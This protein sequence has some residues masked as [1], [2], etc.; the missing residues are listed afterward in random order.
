VG[1]RLGCEEADMSGERDTTRIESDTMG[2]MEIP[3]WA[4]WGAQTQRAVENFAV[5]D[6]RI[7]VSMIKALGLIKRYAA[8]ANRELALLDKKLA[9]AVC[10][11]A[12]EVIEGRW[13][14]HF[15]IDVFQTG[16]GTSWNM[17]ANEVISNRANEILGAPLGAK[18][19][20]HPN[21]H[22]NKGQSSNDVIPTAIHIADRLEIDSLIEA[23]LDLQKALETKAEDFKEV[24]KIGRT[25]LQDAVPM[26]LGQEF[27]GYAS[28][29]RKSVTR[30]KGCLPH[31]EEL[32]LG[33]TAIGT[34][35]NA[36][37]EMA[38]RAIGLIAAKTG[39]PFRTADSL[40]EAI[41]SRDAQ[42]ELMGALNT[43]A[44]AL[45]KIANDLRLLASGPRA[46]F[47]EIVLPSLQPGSSIMPGKVN[48]VIPEMVIQAA[49]HVMGKHYTVSIGAQNAPLELNMMNPLIGYETIASITLLANTCNALAERCI[50]GLEAD[51]ERCAYWVEWS[52]ALVTPLATKI[53]YDKAAAL[54]YKAYKSKRTIRE[55]V[56]EEKIFSDQE[57]DELLDPKRMI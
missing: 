33:G 35:L 14:Q 50:R 13:N 24:I 3:G 21:D 11:A 25:H 17:N 36:H 49:A 41:G 46:G 34:G 4:Y 12:D 39:V 55:I 29:I 32:A 8:E 56:R 2:K 31:L 15:P 1:S 26:T 7:P 20:V 27:E 44:V 16:S 6:K 43:V 53:G 45:M 37:P 52:L 5:S 42:V 47:G 28:Q 38:G 30:V 9:D 22:V 10:Q 40:F 54:A 18:N 23:L 48:P 51:E 57:L 19:P